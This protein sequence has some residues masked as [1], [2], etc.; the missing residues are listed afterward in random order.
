MLIM[1]LINTASIRLTAFMEAADEGKDETTVYTEAV[2]GVYTK[3]INNIEKTREQNS[4]RKDTIS[5]I[6][7]TIS[8]LSIL[9]KSKRRRIRSSVNIHYIY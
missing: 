2:E 6:N 1:R 3:K 9:L 8:L 4:C 7:Q 5:A